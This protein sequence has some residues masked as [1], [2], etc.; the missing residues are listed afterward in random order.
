VFISNCYVN[1]HILYSN[2]SI[3]FTHYPPVAW[4]SPSHL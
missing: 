2:T 4:E 3:S 1:D